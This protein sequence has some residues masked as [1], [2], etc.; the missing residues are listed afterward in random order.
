VLL[1]YSFF[2]D[3]QS[4]IS[5]ILFLAMALYSIYYFITTIT[6]EVSCLVQSFNE[7]QRKAT[8]SKA[9]QG[10]LDALIARNGVVLAAIICHFT[11]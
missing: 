11:C 6:Y 4:L 8:L 3:N 10:D 7:R 9:E 2:L 1:S 5:D